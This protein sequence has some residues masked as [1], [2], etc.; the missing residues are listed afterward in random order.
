MNAVAHLAGL[1]ARSQAQAEPWPTD[2]TASAMDRLDA[3][4][5]RLAERARAGSGCREPVDLQREAVQRFWETRRLETLRDG[6]LVAFGLGLEIAPG[7]GCVLDDPLRLEAVLQA[8][9][10]WRGEPRRYRRCFQG[11]AWSYFN[12][13]APDAATPTVGWRR[14]REHLLQRLPATRDPGGDPDWVRLLAAH[15]SLFGAS[16]CEDFVAPLLRGERAALD[17]LC[18]HLDIGAGSWFRRELVAAQ[19]RRAV[20][21][22]HDGF[23]AALP[24]MLALL[25]G[26]PFR[27]DGLA[28]LLQRYLQLPR[29]PLHAGLRDALTAAWGPAARP[30]DALRW[31]G[32]GDA[33]RKLVGDWQNAHLIDTFFGDAGRRRAAF[34]KRYL[35]SIATLDLAGCPVPQDPAEDP[36]VAAA[37]GRVRALAEGEAAPVR[38]GALVLA[39]GCARLVAFADPAEPAWAYDRRG[40]EPFD[41]DRPLGTVLDGTNSLRRSDRALCL[42]HRDGVDGWR[43]WEQHFEAALRARFGIRTGAAVPCD[44]AGFIDLSDADAA[45]DAVS[46]EAEAAPAERHGERHGEDVHWQTAEAMSVPYSRTDLEVLA[47]VHG[48]GLLPPVPGRFRARVA[49]AGVDARIERVLLRWGFVRDEAGDWARPNAAAPSR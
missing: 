35:G 39:I 18:A 47:R 3:A 31:S 41:L 30:L 7:R 25:D 12:A 45:M 43:Q 4:I 5:A 29:P 48:L 46:T 19:V 36:V 16:P 15:P 24:S 20:G 22:D 10:G 27:D 14:L 38:G 2:A 13:P 34:W 8:T 40:A 37:G 9:D 32:A 33:G 1:L 28:L 17:A 49:A 21:L 11:L 44:A 6:R 42:A 23:V 26:D